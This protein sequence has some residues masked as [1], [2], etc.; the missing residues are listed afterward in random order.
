LVRKSVP[1]HPTVPV[2]ENLLTRFD[3]ASEPAGSFLKAFW[4]SST[5]NAELEAGGEVR[6]GLT[7]GLAV[8]TGDW[9]TADERS[10]RLM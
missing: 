10:E 8:T 4:S 9:A 7:L 6:V 1:I 5:L 3:N 2:T